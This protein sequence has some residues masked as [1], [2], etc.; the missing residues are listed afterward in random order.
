MQILLDTA[1]VETIRRYNE[2]YNISGV[3]SNPTIISREKAGSIISLGVW[4][5]SCRIYIVSRPYRLN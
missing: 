4:H 2:I 5:H 1:N 3:T